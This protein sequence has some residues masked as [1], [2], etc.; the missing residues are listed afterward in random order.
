MENQ[1]EDEVVLAKVTSEVEDNFEDEGLVSNSTLEKVA[2]AKKYIENHYNRRMR[3][4]QQRKERRWVLEQKIASLDVS[5][6][7]QLELLEDLQ[8]KETEYT[9]LMRNRLCVDDFDLLSII[10][11]GAFGEVRLCR[12]KKTGNIYAMKKLKK[13]EMLSRGQVSLTVISFML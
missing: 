13:S 4:I 3:H 11:R 10:G 8:R 12:E 5:E 7:E 2:A 6:K 9:R 1:E